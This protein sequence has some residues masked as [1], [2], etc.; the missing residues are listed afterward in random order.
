MYVYVTTNNKMLKRNLTYFQVSGLYY[1]NAASLKETNT[2][3]ALC[4]ICLSYIQ[5]PCFFTSLNN[6]P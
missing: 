6:K 4:A 2:L 3:T 1:K 5:Q